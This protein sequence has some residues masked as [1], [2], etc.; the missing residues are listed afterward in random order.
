MSGLLPASVIFVRNSST[1]CG[2]HQSSM[3]AKWP[4]IGILILA[5]SASAAGRQ[6]GE[7][8]PPAG[9]RPPAPAAEGGAPPPPTPPPPPPRPRPPPDVAAAPRAQLPPP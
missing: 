3:M 7:R 9:P 4:W 2:V 6:P 5:G 1:T 8:T